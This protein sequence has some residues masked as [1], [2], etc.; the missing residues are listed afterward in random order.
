MSTETV[1]HCQDNNSIQ[2]C[3][4]ASANQIK[5]TE[6]VQ[7]II[8]QY[9]SIDEELNK[10]LDGGWGW[11]IV[12]ASFLTHLLIGEWKSFYINFF[13]YFFYLRS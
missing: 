7:P 9:E 5:D 6:S 10:P 2:S 13:F 4:N 1:N 3:D 11:F 8:I 12:I